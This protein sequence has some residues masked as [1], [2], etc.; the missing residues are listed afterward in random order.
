MLCDTHSRNY[1]R[2][3]RGR[4]I[5]F[6]NE[7]SDN[8]MSF[9]YIVAMDIVYETGMYSIYIVEIRDFSPP[10]SQFPVSLLPICLRALHQGLGFAGIISPRSYF[11]VTNIVMKS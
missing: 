3:M 9:S 2:L 11:T 7:K 5:D 1:V 10:P 4:K 6:Y 8:S